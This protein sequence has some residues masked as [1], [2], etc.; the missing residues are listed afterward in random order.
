LL[1]FFFNFFSLFERTI[2]VGHIIAKRRLPQFDKQRQQ[3]ALLDVRRIGVHNAH[4]R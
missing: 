1:L 4:E 2:I 3:L